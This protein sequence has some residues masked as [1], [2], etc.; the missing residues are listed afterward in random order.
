[1]ILSASIRILTPTKRIDQNELL[2]ENFS[3]DPSPRKDSR[4]QPLKARRMNTKKVVNCTMSCM[5]IRHR[6]WAYAPVCLNTAAYLNT[7]I[8][9]SKN[10]AENTNHCSFL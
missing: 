6:I 1:M 10:A 8:V 4:R 5:R 9:H 3:N 2:S 7:R